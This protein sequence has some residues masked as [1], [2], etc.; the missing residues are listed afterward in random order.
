MT[1][2]EIDQLAK[3]HI[4]WNSKLLVDMGADPECNARQIIGGTASPYQMYYGEWVFLV[5]PQGFAIASMTGS[6]QTVAPII[7][8]DMNSSDGLV[9]IIQDVISPF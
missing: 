6:G 3:H 9:Y 1:Q 2:L 4:F 7:T 5:M 8:P